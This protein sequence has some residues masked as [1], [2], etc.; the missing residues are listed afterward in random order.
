LRYP[1]GKS[2]AISQL[3]PF[4]PAAPSTIISPFFGG[5][6]VE[7][8]L[9]ARGW[10]V[11]GFDAYRPL[12]DFWQQALTDRMRL[13]DEVTKHYP[14]TVENFKRLQVEGYRLQT[15]LER[16]A[17]FYVLN[18]S[19]FSGTTC[20]GGMSPG[21]ARFNLK[22]IER[23]RQFRA[24]NLWV[25]KADFKR[26]ISEH[27]NAFLFCDPPYITARRLYGRN[28]NLHDQF[29]HE[30]LRDLLKGRG[31]WLLCYGDCSDARYMYGGRRIVPLQWKWGMSRHKQSNEAVILSDD[32]PVPCAL[33]AE[34][35]RVPNPLADVLEELRREVVPAGAG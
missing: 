31:Q 8:A 9:A 17:A 6:S 3:L 14:L 23:L 15:Q 4:F 2:R 1:G 34:R 10:R 11:L 32:L 35:L 26:S 5:G 30:G 28:G 20:S 13:A 27:P 19:S 7:L 22:A 16:A 18:R 33:C 24:P 12:V 25:E 21:H 29:D